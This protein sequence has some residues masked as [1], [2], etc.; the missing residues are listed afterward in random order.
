[1]ARKTGENV[2]GQLGEHADLALFQIR[3][4]RL[5][6]VDED[7]RSNLAININGGSLDRSLETAPDHRP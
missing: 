5:V 4:V 3:I 2:A 1:M 7:M 6:E